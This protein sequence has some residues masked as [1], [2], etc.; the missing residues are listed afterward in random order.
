MACLVGPRMDALVERALMP[1][2]EVV[3]RVAFGQN[4]ALKARGYHWQPERKVWTRTLPIAWLD[5]ERAWCAG[6]GGK[7]EPSQK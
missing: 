3:A 7:V 2:C 6:I 1:E 5:D 4:D